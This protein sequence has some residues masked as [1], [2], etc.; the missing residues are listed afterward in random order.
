MKALRIRRG[1]SIA[2]LGML[3]LALA[4]AARF[5]GECTLGGVA[6]GTFM[7]ARIRAFCMA[8]ML[9]PWQRGRKA[10]AARPG[11][12]LPCGTSVGL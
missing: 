11:A 6:A 5:A 7:L 4:R 10:R 9:V 2:L 1:Q 12:W 8:C 3:L